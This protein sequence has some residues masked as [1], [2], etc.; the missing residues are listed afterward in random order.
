MPVKS[1]KPESQPATWM[2]SKFPTASRRLSFLVW[3]GLI[4]L[5][6]LHIVVAHIAFVLLDCT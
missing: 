2:T 6:R 5:I 4:S 3:H 1:T